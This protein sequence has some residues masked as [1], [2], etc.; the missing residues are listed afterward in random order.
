MPQDGVG[1]REEWAT[2]KSEQGSSG[3]QGEVVQGSS[4]LQ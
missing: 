2:E 4:G 3:P 1:H